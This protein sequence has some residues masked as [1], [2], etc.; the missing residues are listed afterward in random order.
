MSHLQARVTLPDELQR[1]IAPLRERW[2]PERALGN[3]AHVTIVY[4]DEASDAD[5]LEARLRAT[6][7]NLTPFEL[8]VDGPARFPDPARGAFLRVS[9][10]TNAISFVRYEVLRPPFAPRRRFGLHVT[11]LHP[12]QRQRFDEAW[13]EIS[14]FPKLGT[15]LVSALQLVDTCNE[16]K[17]N[18]GLATDR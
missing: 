1:R 13:P 16:T 15:F 18:I 4:Q 17:A 12:D 14:K 10:L 2:N 3:P 6:A 8:S 9:D 5:L 11:V 7:C